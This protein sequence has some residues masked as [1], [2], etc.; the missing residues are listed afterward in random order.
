V[1][2][3]TGQTWVAKD[4]SRLRATSPHIQ[5]L[6][7]SGLTCKIERFTRPGYRIDRI[8]IKELRRRYTLQHEQE[9]LV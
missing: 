3:A 8:T 7:V 5:I 9:R 4:P 2:P 1:K 6:E